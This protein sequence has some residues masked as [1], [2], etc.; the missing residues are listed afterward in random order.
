M[1]TPSDMAGRLRV[2]LDYS[3]LDQSAL[4]LLAGLAPAH[5]NMILRGKIAQP[6]GK[7]LASLCDV[8]GVSLDWL[9]RGVGA[10]P[11]EDSVRAAVELA[12]ANA[13]AKL[14]AAS[15]E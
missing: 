3:G 14:A 1:E 10:A 6:S 9:M 8:L 2:L 5:V 11:D 15:G 7:T 13:P 4:S 12:Q